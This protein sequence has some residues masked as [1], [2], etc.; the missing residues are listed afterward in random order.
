MIMHRK[1][2][3][4]DRQDPPPA[5][6]DRYAVS[7]Y[8]VWHFEAPETCF[9]HFIDDTEKIESS[10]YHLVSFT[11]EEIVAFQRSRVN[12]VDD[13]KDSFDVAFTAK[14]IGWLRVRFDLYLKQQIY[15][16]CWGEPPIHPKSEI[17]MAIL[18]GYNFSSFK[19]K[20]QVE[21]EFINWR[22][23]KEICLK[24]ANK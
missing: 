2:L 16:E 4:I 5:P 12:S 14:W 8:N 19:N 6:I 15:R 1:Q 17:G 18:N 24:H 3:E 20:K 9:E 22:N 21:E 7:Y 23:D 10:W 13:S 11:P